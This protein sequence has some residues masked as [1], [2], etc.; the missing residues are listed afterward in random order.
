MKHTLTLLLLFFF[1]IANA[2]MENFDPYAKFCLNF[3]E[4]INQESEV[5]N[6][7]KNF[8]SSLRDDDLK[9][10]LSTFKTNYLAIKPLSETYIAK[11]NDP[12]K[13]YYNVQI[14]NRDN[15]EPYAD[16]RFLFQDFD[17]YLIDGWEYIPTPKQEIVKKEVEQIT[18]QKEETQ[19]TYSAAKPKTKEI[20]VIDYQ[21]VVE[22][23]T[24]VAE[25]SQETNNDLLSGNQPI[26]LDDAVVQLIRISNSQSNWQQTVD[27]LFQNDLTRSK[28]RLNENQL[29]ELRNHFLTKGYN[30]YVQKVAD[31]YR[32][33]FTTEEILALANFY[34]TP[35]GRSVLN[36]MSTFDLNTDDIAKEIKNQMVLEYL[37]V[38]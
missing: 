36:K 31:V 17:D 16:V 24:S 4:T 37:N 27:A 20:E 28:V 34:R 6:L 18:P 9:N 19:V 10:Q 3:V 21:P 13:F 22:K 30:I 5:E 29:N 25:P 32:K 8:N 23:P 14:Y 7:M 1:S 12:A 2:Q 11:A 26:G 33:N 35:A 15:N 38:E